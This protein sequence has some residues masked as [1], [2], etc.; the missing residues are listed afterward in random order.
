MKKQLIATTIIA[1]GLA[2]FAKPTRSNSGGDGTARSGGQPRPYDSKVEYLQST[3]SEAVIIPASVA[4]TITKYTFDCVYAAAPNQS[5]SIS[6]GYLG[7]ACYAGKYR[8]QWTRYGSYITTIFAT[9]RITFELDMTAHTCSFFSASGELL[10]TATDGNIKPTS[11]IPIRLFG[12]T[13]AGMVSA[14]ARVF[15][16]VA[17]SGDSIALDLIP[18]RKDGLGYRYDKISGQLFGNEGTG[19]FVLGPDVP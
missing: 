12:T 1:I 13:S 14:Q 11:D 19:A 17:Y 6:A 5:V 8:C 10:E 3:G 16:F 15:G 9:T 4:N 18:V 2:L 7:L